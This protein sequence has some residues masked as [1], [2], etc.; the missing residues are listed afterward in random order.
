[1]RIMALA[2]TLALMPGGSMGPLGELTDLMVRRIRAGDLVAAAKFGTP[3]PIDDPVRERQVLEDVR[4]R[5]VAMGLDPESAVR[6]FRAQIEA[7]KAVQRG[8]YVRWTRH[9]D[10]VPDE[11][12]DLLTDVRRRLDG[13]T[14]EILVDLKET[15]QLRR[16]VVS[17]EV[18]AKLAE[19]SA[20]VVHHLDE[21]H[22]DALA[23]AMRAVCS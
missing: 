12:P 9:P 16:S 15:E 22:E 23:R 4:T 2:L 21:V 17:C 8:L 20:A 1:M 3:R 10:E 18:Q 11:R 7:N 5:S 14:T 13:L 6:F 19:R